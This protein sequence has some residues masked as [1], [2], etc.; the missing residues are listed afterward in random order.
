VLDKRNASF[1]GKGVTLTKYTG[2]RG[3]SGSNDAN[4]KHACTY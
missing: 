4:A 1:I 2:S 3:K